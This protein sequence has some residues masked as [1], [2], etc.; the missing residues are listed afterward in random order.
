MAECR[1]PETLMVIAGVMKTMNQ[2]WRVFLLFGL[3]SGTLSSAASELDVR[4]IQGG[5]ALGVEAVRFTP[6][7]KRLISA[8]AGGVKFWGVPD[9][10][11]QKSLGTTFP[12]EM[13]IDL[14][15]D[16]EWLVSANRL[17]AERIVIRQLP[18]GETLHTLP[19]GGSRMV[20]SLSFS[21]GRTRLAAIADELLHVW[22]TETRSLLTG[23]SIT[24]F[25]P[26]LNWF[27]GMAL[28]ADNELL[29][30][31]MA[32]L[33]RAA[34][35]PFEVH[36]HNTNAFSFAFGISADRSVFAGATS[37]AVLLIRTSD[38]ANLRSFPAREWAFSIAVSSDASLVAAGFQDGEIELWDAGQSAVIHKL[39]AGGPFP[40]KL[41]FAPDGRLLAAAHLYGISLWNLPDPGPAME[42]VPIPG[43]PTALSVSSNGMIGLATQ[44]YVCLFEGGNG[45]PVNR[46]KMDLGRRQVAIAP[47]G[48]WIAA[49][50]SPGSVVVYNV[51]E[52]TVRATLPPMEGYSDHMLVSPDELWLAIVRDTR[53]MVV[54]TAGW[55]PVR[56]VQLNSEQGIG[57]LAFSPDSTLLAAGV[58]P[59]RIHIWNVSD[60]SSSRII[61]AGEHPP[62]FLQFS[63][64]GRRLLGLASTGHI[65]TWNVDSGEMI[66][67]VL[68]GAA[69]SRRAMWLPDQSAILTS[70]GNQPFRLWR[71]DTGALIAEISG[72]ALPGFS[73]AAALPD[74]R[75]F[76][77]ARVDGSLLAAAMPHFLKVA[78]RTENGI[79]LK[80]AGF[81]GIFQMERRDMENGIW[82][83]VGPP[84]SS[85]VTIPIPVSQAGLFRS[86]VV[87]EE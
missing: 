20:T 32:G 48:E 69:N 8:D 1:E 70:R 64:D 62:V 29:A 79:L 75:S 76:A 45:K 80:P 9:G 40:Y 71:T 36:W 34:I 85:A 30:V 19:L 6:D 74:G 12:D 50:S 4:W 82:E 15:D 68:S 65:R 44:G 54:P 3:F 2:S 28:L 60:E 84:F 78:S 57:R 25:H 35:Q 26:S 42:L 38:G 37:N 67:E 81:S 31:T 46:W 63:A 5:T 72:S 47:S 51:P 22:D 77:F 73:A 53:L 41:S 86:K 83:N 13:V 61:S 43:V 87:N 16:G 59:D 14:S 24:D 39:E 10:E 21:P 66:H 17:R 55:S 49:D 52:G 56:L 18:S 7:A 27:G 58:A 33:Y 23:P 11:L